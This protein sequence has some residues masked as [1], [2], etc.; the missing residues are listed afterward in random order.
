[1]T[2]PVCEWCKGQRAW[3]DVGRW[4]SDPDTWTD[5]PYC[6]PQFTPPPDY[7]KDLRRDKE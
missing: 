5:C 6:R 4:A 3:K 7:L 1:M 2:H